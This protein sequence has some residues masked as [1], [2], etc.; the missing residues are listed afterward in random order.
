MTGRRT[1]PTGLKELFHVQ[2]STSSSSWFH[3]HSLH[4]LGL[5]TPPNPLSACNQ[6]WKKKKCY[7]QKAIG[8]CHYH[9][10]RLQVWITLRLAY[11]LTLWLDS[12]RPLQARA[13][14]W[15]D[16]AECSS[17]ITVELSTSKGYVYG[18]LEIISFSKFWLIL[19]LYYSTHVKIT[20]DITTI[21]RYD[22]IKVKVKRNA[23]LIPV[24]DRVTIIKH[25]IK[26]FL[27]CVP[28]TQKHSRRIH[29]ESFKL[30]T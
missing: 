6:T 22:T 24:N 10:L 3:V 19:L 15:W 1:I 14:L 16:L 20:C 29:L 11:A 25:N 4:C 7:D 30:L 28:H 23:Q 5:L 12:V 21:N 27:T 2:R 8:Y 13:K 9:S 17:I 18:V 26:I